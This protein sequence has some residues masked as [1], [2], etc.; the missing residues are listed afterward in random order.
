MKKTLLFLSSVAGSLASCGGILS[1]SSFSSVDCADAATCFGYPG[2]PGS[3]FGNYGWA[4]IS[5]GDC[6]T[7][8]QDTASYFNSYS[9]CLATSAFHTCIYD[10]WNK[11][12]TNT[13]WILNNHFKWADQTLICEQV[14]CEA[15]TAWADCLREAYNTDRTNCPTDYSLCLAEECKP[16]LGF[17]TKLVGTSCATDNE[18]VTGSCAGVRVNPWFGSTC[19]QRHVEPN[20]DSQ[21]SGCTAPAD[22]TYAAGLPEPTWRALRG[23]VEAQKE[24]CAAID[25]R[26]DT[27]PYEVARIATDPETPHTIEYTEPV[28]VTSSLSFSSG[29]VDSDVAEAYFDKVCS[30]HDSLISVLSDRSITVD[31]ET[32]EA[33]YAA[34][35]QVNGWGIAVGQKCYAGCDPSNAA[36]FT[37]L[38]LWALF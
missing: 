8:S 28:C 20:D 16:I 30:D 12:Q 27:I 32:Q 11:V 6:P 25:G 31:V 10:G 35:D 5:Y 34:R 1:S 14:E 23:D 3:G 18:C 38:L 4:S 33:C 36:Q 19:Y 26:M 13:W 9:N 29:V 15:Y 22:G 24:L 37:A 21:W 2:F 7:V 17:G